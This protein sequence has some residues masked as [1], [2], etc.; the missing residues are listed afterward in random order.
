MAGSEEN[1]S[2]DL[3]SERVNYL[4]FNSAYFVVK[5]RHNLLKYSMILHTKRSNKIDIHLLSIYDLSDY[6]K[7]TKV[8]DWPF[9][10]D[11]KSPLISSQSLLP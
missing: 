11:E 6:K 3:G 5:M 2:Q 1:Y 9:V 8:T 7:I 10:M 4:Y